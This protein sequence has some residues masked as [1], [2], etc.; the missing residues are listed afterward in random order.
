MTIV[1]I[2]IGILIFGIFIAVHELG[3]F[4]AAKA[5]GVKVTEFSI[6]MGP[7]L[8]KKQ[9]GE[10]LY[11]LRA[12]PIGGFCAM[13]EDEGE[14]DDP[15]AFVNKA[16]WKRF[17]ILVAGAFM[18]F[19]V[20]FLVLLVLVPGSGRYRQPVLTGFYE[21][22]PYDSPDGLRE[23]DEFYKLDGHRIYFKS[24]LDL[25]IP[26]GTGVTTL[27]SSGTARG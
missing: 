14:S 19:L 4:L 13:D 8:Y 9:K 18:N 25:F 11:S 27:S 21:G 20:G 6:G 16:W 7:K 23:G 24:D 3:H 2:F 5:C 12:L 10:T 17:I 22:C 26:R 1:F 15:R